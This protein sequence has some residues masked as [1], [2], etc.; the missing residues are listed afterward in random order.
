[1][2]LLIVD[3]HQ[4][5][6]EGVKALIVQAAP[7]NTVLQANSCTQALSIVEAEHDLDA[8]LLD[9]SMPDMDG[10]KAITAFGKR[11]PDLPV[12]VL[13]ASDDRQTIKEALSKGAMGYIPKASNP[14]TL[15]SALQFILDGNVYVPPLFF[16]RLAKDEENA[17]I[18]R[19]RYLE[20][21]GFPLTERQIE[22][23]KLIDVG[24]SNKAI[25]RKLGLSEKT[26]KVHVTA[27]LKSLNVG[28]RTQ[29]VSVARQAK[30]I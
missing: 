16:D 7:S 6:R 3:D 22:V 30:L 1:M 12:I 15:L 19:T 28:N 18:G 26:V 17:T 5:L 8:V 2:K 20:N 14:K 23:L 21:N 29:A 11:R 10:M 24:L 25:S 13:S 9:L 4:I 27:I